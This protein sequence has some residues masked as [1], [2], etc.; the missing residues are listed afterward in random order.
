[1]AP[2]AILT[3]SEPTVTSEVLP[4]ECRTG[5]TAPESKNIAVHVTIR[6]SDSAARPLGRAAVNGGPIS[7]NLITSSAVLRNDFR[8]GALPY[9]DSPLRRAEAPMY[10]RASL[11]ESYCVSECV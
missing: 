7:S 6:S 3:V 1:M 9:R 4:G 2:A 5:N 11:K 10:G 8:H